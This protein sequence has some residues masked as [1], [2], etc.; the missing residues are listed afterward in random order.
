MMSATQRESG[1]RKLIGIVDRFVKDE[2]GATAIEYG[3]IVSLIFVAI[4]GAVRQYA[5]NTSDMYS[6]IAS[7]LTN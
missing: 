1:K 7:N 5:N 4:I 6:E 2:N 3:L